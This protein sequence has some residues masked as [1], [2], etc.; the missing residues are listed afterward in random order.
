M[1]KNSKSFILSVIVLILILI[2]LLFIYS[3]MNNTNITI[4]EGVTNK[5]S[6]NFII[7]LKNENSNQ[8]DFEN[9][10][11]KID[12][13]NGIPAEVEYNITSLP[14][15]N[16]NMDSQIVSF[17]ENLPQQVNLEALNTYIEK[18]TTS[19][20]F[21]ITKLNSFIV[22][23]PKTKKSFPSNFQIKIENNIEE[24][25][26]QFDLWG[27]T[28]INQNAMRP[29]GNTNTIIGPHNLHSYIDATS[30]PDIFLYNKSIFNDICFAKNTNECKINNMEVGNK[31]INV[32]QSGG[33]FDNN[34]TKIGNAIK[35]NRIKNVSM[36]TIIIDIEDTNDITGILIYI[37][38]PSPL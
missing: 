24:N 38:Y 9:V 7:T 12:I 34:G 25:K 17:K 15:D 31:I 6:T 33:I 10:N 27:D 20:E 29:I 26:I 23:S 28:Y 8:S 2:S 18:G 32:I 13:G 36:E 37:G 21:D 19:V 1:I 14:S 3:V 11:T 22:I 5:I 16:H 35:M 30:N 4:K